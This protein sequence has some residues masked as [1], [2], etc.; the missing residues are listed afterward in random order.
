MI[1]IATKEE[2]PFLYRLHMHPSVNPWLLYEY[3]TFEEFLPIGTDLVHRG[4]K[5]LYEVDGKPVGM[6]KLQ[7]MKYRNS[8]IA[9]LGGVAIDPEW[10]G[11]G[12]G[13]MMIDAA[14]GQA[15]SSGFTRMEL[16]V[17]TTNT[18]AIRL[19][20]SLGFMSEGILKNYTY[21]TSEKRYVDEQV[22]GLIFS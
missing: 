10:S 21:L 11:K 6:C 19:Y 8:H 16:T 15:R 9:Y 17:A 5:W 1:R 18:R 2:I 7:P 13:K 12:H 22:M 4:I 3:M 20:E 14:I